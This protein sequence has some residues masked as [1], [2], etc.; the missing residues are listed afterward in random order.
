MCTQ[1]TWCL[2]KVSQ[3]VHKTT[4]CLF[5]VST[6]SLYIK[7]EYK[8]EGEEKSVREAEHL[9]LSKRP[10][11]LATF[12]KSAIARSFW[13]EVVRYLTHQRGGVNL[14]VKMACKIW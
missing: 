4:W 3:C 9:E 1:A 11:F 13:Q 12:I 2:F 7:Q 14:N 10:T 6:V 5:K 8:I